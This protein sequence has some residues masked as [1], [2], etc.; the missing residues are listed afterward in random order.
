MKGDLGTWDVPR[1]PRGKAGML[2]IEAKLVG[3]RA[4]GI[5]V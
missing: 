2:G 1:Q 3:T 5:L 4:T